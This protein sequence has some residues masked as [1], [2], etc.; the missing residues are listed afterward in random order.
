MMLSLVLSALAALPLA[1]PQD[2]LS[3]QVKEYKSIL[4][5]R[6][7][8]SEAIAL[9]DAFTTRYAAHSERL[10]EIADMLEIEEGDAKALKKEAKDIADEQED[11]ADLIW[12]AFKERKRMTEGHRRLWKAAVFSFGQMG[13]HGAKH[14]W[15]VYGD[16][17]FKDREEVGFRGTCIEQ[18][19]M[20]KDWDQWEDLVDLL[21]H[22]ED[23]I[24]AAS[25]TALKN[26]RG[27]PG[28]VRLEVCAKLVNFL[29]S[30]YNAASNPEDTTARQRYRM[31]GRP[32]SDAL[33]EMTG[34]TFQDPLD[35]R[36]WYN[37]NKKNKEIWSDD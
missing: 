34:Q 8:E 6:E 36:K 27:A 35:W 13:P 1:A 4:D 5:D 19:G 37:D 29:N 22:H 31:V 25:A 23:V 10:V 3:E 20:T 21:D 15:K 33:S 14:L 32:M 24:I 2:S 9:I 18:I 7:R 11:L 30:Y 12:L 26:Y 16:K 28:K 17:R